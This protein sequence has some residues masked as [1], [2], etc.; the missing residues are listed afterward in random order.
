MKDTY[1]TIR[2]ASI[3]E[4]NIQR[5]RFIGY[6]YPVSTTEE[7]LNSLSELRKE[8]YSATHVCWAYSIYAGETNETRFSD[9]GEP[10]GTA[11]KPI[12]GRLISHDLTNVVVGVVRYFGGLKLGTSGLIEAY[13]STAGLV[14]GQSTRQEVI[15]YSTVT[16]SYQMHLMGP[17]MQ[18]VKSVGADIIAQDYTSEYLLTVRLRQGEMPRFLKIVGEIYGVM[19]H[20]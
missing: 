11:G 4:Q 19:I 5:S 6:S 7:A 13:R 3:A 20:Q 10:S 15:L 16:L 17:V 14:L 8:H 1:H 9:D 2:S 12:L 18:L